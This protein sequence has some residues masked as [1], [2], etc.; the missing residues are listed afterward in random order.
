VAFGHFLLGSHS[1][2]HGS[3]LVCEVALKGHELGHHSYYYSIF[4]DLEPPD[5][6]DIKNCWIF[7]FEFL[8]TLRNER[9]INITITDNLS[10]ST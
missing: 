9:A 10:I 5:D 6:W 1:H 4:Y 8:E 3:W 2:G 7:Q